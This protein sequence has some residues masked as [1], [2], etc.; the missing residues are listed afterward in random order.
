MKERKERWNDLCLYPYIYIFNPRIYI[1][2]EEERS[3]KNAIVKTNK[4]QH[5]YIHIW[6]TVCVC[7]AQDKNY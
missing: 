5:I 1:Q 3:K 7:S 2:Y 4:K 6:C